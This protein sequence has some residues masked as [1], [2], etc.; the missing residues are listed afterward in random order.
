MR[1]EIKVLLI[2][3]DPLESH[4]LNEQLAEVSEYD[5]MVKNAGLLAEGLE[6]LAQEPFD[7]VLL[8]QDLGDIQGIGSLLQLC[9]QSPAIPIIG[10]TD[11]ANE[12]ITSRSMQMEVQDYLIKGQIG[13]EQLVHSIRYTLERKHL[14]EALQER[15][16]RYK[17]LID[18]IDEGYSVI[19]MRIDPGRPLDYRFL[20]VNRAF[21][22]QSTL[23]DAVGKWMRE[24]RP[25]HEEYWFEI[26]RDVALTG[27]P[28]RFEH[29]GRALGGRCFSVYAFRIDPPDRRQVAVLFSDITER[30]RV[31]KALAESEQ[32]LQLFIEHAPAALA[33]FD[34]DMRYLSLSRRWSADY[35]LGDRD[36]V[37]LPAYEVHDIPERWKEIHRRG[38]AGEVL[39]AKEER[40]E[41]PDGS[42]RWVCWEIHPWYDVSG[43]IGGIVIF[44]EDITERKEVEEDL[45]TLNEELGR[46][47]EERTREL[48]E[49][50]SQYL[51]AE[52]L[53][54]IGKLSAS[55]AHEFNNP[56]Q[57]VIAILKG[58]KKLSGLEEEDKELLDLAL[59]ETDR[60]KNLI[61]NL[62]EF[63]RPSSAKKV[64]MDVHASIN[65]LLLLCKSDFKR[66]R[67]VTILNYSEQLPWII[68]V[69]DQIKQVFLNLLNNAA[70]AIRNDGVITVRTWQEDNRV[71]VAIQDTGTGIAPEQMDLIFQPFHTTKPESQGTGLGLSVCQGIVRNHRGEIRVESEPGKG[72]TFTVLLPVGEES[73]ESESIEKTPGRSG[74]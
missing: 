72:S 74:S 11:A 47:V 19:E 55:I 73:M 39:G 59:S 69:P 17:S 34:R 15:E 41:Q 12:I 9:R 36:L 31:E 7:L 27:K 3:D 66:R 44:T 71:A 18:T 57:G 4:Y 26:Y 54:A 49:T 28:T 33:M 10:L 22:Q 1:K 65:T 29:C 40:Y 53:S 48:Q 63:N 58:L 61:R 43:D 30:K 38:L 6:L 13:K 64:R 23:A 25:D 42:V 37:G 21:E 24:L 56:L 70:D 50:Q 20:E 46:R 45:Q 68:A 32:R 16:N 62:Q 2:D 67:I 52:K 51:H 60:M 5:C 14:T 35:E 8:D